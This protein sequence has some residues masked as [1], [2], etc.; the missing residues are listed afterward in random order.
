MITTLS[1]GVAIGGGEE[2]VAVKVVPK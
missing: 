2:L 1:F